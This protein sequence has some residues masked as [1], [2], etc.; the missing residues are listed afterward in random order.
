MATK[1]RFTNCRWKIKRADKHI[2]EMDGILDSF[3]KPDSYTVREDRDPHTGQKF[4]EYGFAKILSGEDLALAM[5]DAVHNLKCAL[6]YAWIHCIRKLHPPALRNFAKFPIYPSQ[7][8][9]ESALRG[10]G[11]QI[12]SPT[13]YNLIVSEIKPYDGGDQLWAIHRTDIW[14][15]HRLLIPVLD[16]AQAEVTLEDDKGNL[17]VWLCVFTRGGRYSHPIEDNQKLKDKGD[18]HLDV[19]FQDGLPVQ[20]KHI[21]PV[22]HEFS[23]AVLAVVETLEAFL[24]T[25]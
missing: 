5:G 23:E 9:L 12:A 19:V 3:H 17:N 13:F 24:E 11:I 8:E 7:P 25:A 18:V 21:S 15:K 4:I 16:V 22:L 14:D 1:L 2:A 6:D 10:H 20:G